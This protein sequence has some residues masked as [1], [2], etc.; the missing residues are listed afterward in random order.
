MSR[1][2]VG[3]RIWQEMSLPVP[4]PFSQVHSVTEKRVCLWTK[5]SLFRVCNTGNREFNNGHQDDFKWDGF[6][7]SVTKY[8]EKLPS[9]FSS[10]FRIIQVKSSKQQR[11]S[12]R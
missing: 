12:R 8:K 10:L 1:P 2:G 9:V 4:G 11:S 6:C 7:N 5:T 3:E